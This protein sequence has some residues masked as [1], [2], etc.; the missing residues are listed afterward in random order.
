MLI[1]CFVAGVPRMPSTIPRLV[2]VE[3]VELPV[4]ALRHRPVIAMMRIEAVVYMPVKSTT[5]VEP[6][7][8]SNKYSAIK[9]VR[10]IIAV[11]ST[12]IGFIVEVPVR[13]FRRHAN[14]DADLRT[15]LR[16]ATN[17]RNAESRK[18]KNFTVGH[19]FSF[20]LLGPRG[21]GDL[22]LQASVSLPRAPVSEQ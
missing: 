11:G 9:P 14:T 2:P 4:P 21:C 20:N 3:V 18:S 8:C 5:A 17:H 19:S 15:P 6:W 12:L 7:P 10:P 16:C 22:N 1:T 13:A